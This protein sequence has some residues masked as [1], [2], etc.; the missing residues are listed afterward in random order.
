MLIRFGFD[1]GAERGETRRSSGWVGEWGGVLRSRTQEGAGE[2]Q[3]RGGSPPSG[4]GCDEA[5]MALRRPGGGIGERV[6]GWV[7]GVDLAILG[8]ERRFKPRA[9]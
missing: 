8:A 5:D 7:Q 4:F 9:G 3:V 6:D 2:K 1:V